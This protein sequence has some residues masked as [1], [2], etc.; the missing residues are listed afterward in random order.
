MAFFNL[1]ELYTLSTAREKI[2]SR[3][4]MLSVMRVYLSS[5][6]KTSFLLLTCVI[7][8][9]IATAYYIYF[10]VVQSPVPLSTNL[11]TD[12]GLASLPVQET[13]TLLNVSG[14]EL[15]VSTTEGVEKRFHLPEGATVY[16][17]ST[18][19]EDS[20][21]RE[22]SADTLRI[23]ESIDITYSNSFA[24]TIEAHSVISHT[25]KSLDTYFEENRAPAV[26]KVRIVSIDVD[27]ATLKYM[28]LDRNGEAL[29]DVPVL[30]IKLADNLSIE[31]VSG[32]EKAH[33]SHVRAKTS[34]TFD[35][36]EPQDAVIIF[37]PA[38]IASESPS[39]LTL[40]ILNN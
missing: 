25:E 28:L 11:D 1:V 3:Y 33:L 38:I 5:V 9:C 24:T 40:V 10:K 34:T 36:I 23:G 4:D 13:F 30:S 16:K 14:P 2:W 22:I 15:L 35:K 27:N 26:M 12:R 32:F 21:L 20:I 31:T 6:S 37:E 18:L 8:L 17:S 29:K 39:V 7:L 19:E